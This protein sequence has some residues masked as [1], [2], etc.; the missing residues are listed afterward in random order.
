MAIVPS[1]SLPFHLF[2]SLFF[3]FFS[4]AAKTKDRQC[5]NCTHSSMLAHTQERER[6]RERERVYP[7]KQSAEGTSTCHGRKYKFACPNPRHCNLDTLP[8]LCLACPRSRRPELKWPPKRQRVQQHVG[9][10]QRCKANCV[11]TGTWYR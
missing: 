5:A 7:Y 8:N 3:V 9:R 1:T 10:L 11:C 2:L 6:E 4:L